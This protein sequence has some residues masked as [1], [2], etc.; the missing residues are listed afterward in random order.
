MSL[1]IKNIKE[2]TSDAGNWTQ[3]FLRKVH[4]PLC[5]SDS[6][7]GPPQS[8][9]DLDIGTCRDS[10]RSAFDSQARTPGHQSLL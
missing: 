10:K 5:Q 6:Y 8:F 3:I 9:S 4:Y 7:S 1:N 2:L